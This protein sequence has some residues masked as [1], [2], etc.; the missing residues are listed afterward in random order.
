MVKHV[1]LGLLLGGLVF[2]SALFTTSPAEADIL[3]FSEDFSSFN[4]SSMSGNG[5]WFATY[6]TDP[7]SANGDFVFANT[8]DWGGVFGSGGGTD[9][10]LMYTGS[11]WSDFIFDVDMRSQ[12]ND[13][14]GVS[15]RFTD[16]SNYYLVHLCGGDGYPRVPD[17]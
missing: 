7:W 3:D 13:T 14:I 5:G 4:T 17:A 1:V 11:S 8:D 9:N 6:A 16:T 10:H 15:F 12:D 2:V